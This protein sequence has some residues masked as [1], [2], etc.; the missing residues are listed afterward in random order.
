VKRL[1]FRADD[2]RLEGK[3]FSLETYGELLLTLAGS[4]LAAF[5]I[6]RRFILKR[7]LACCGHCSKTLS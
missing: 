2:I 6:D 4:V 1:E 5:Y 3:P 7:K